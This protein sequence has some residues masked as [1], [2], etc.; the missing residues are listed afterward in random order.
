MTAPEVLRYTAFSS[1]S[2]GGNP[3]GVVLDARGLDDAAM[4]SIASEIDFSETAFVTGETSDGALAV[5]YFSPIAEVP[6]CGHATVATAVALADRGRSDAG[7]TIRFATAAGP[8]AIA[9]SRDGEGIRAAFTS[10]P[11]SV[12]ELR[13]ADLAAILRLLDLEPAALDPELP[14][15]MAH[16]GN[17]HPI[18]AIA[19]R[20]VFDAFRFSPDAA[21]T[22]MDDRGWP[23]TIT[24]I[25][26]AAPDRF[27]ARNLFPVGRITEDP[28]TGSAAAA[29]GAY[30]RE[31]EVV[32]VP[33]RIMIEQ[34]A[35]VGRPG[36]LT[37]DIPASGGI[38]V[39]GH[40]VPLE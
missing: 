29:L 32:P 9:L 6:F 13:A 5:R 3:A 39:S 17:P 25:H 26:R 38:V 12:T 27:I 30:L 4:Q 8:V 28:A 1:R 19:A 36:L 16:A 24:V 11:P 23:A 33:G 40:A 35:H 18:V 7:D 14:P 37:V 2:D 34:G 15:R 22:L 20:D 10:I 31:L 21:R